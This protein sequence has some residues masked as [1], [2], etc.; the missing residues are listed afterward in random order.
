MYTHFGRL[1]WRSIFMTLNLETLN[2]LM[3]IIKQDV[4]LL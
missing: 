4:M 1:L 2:N 3:D